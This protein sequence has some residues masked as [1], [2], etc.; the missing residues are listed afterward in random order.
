MFRPIVLLP[1]IWL[2]Q[3]CRRLRNYYD[4]HHYHG[5]QRQNDRHP[6]PSTS[7]IGRFLLLHHQTALHMPPPPLP[8]PPLTPLNLGHSLTLEKNNKTGCYTENPKTV[9]PGWVLPLFSLG[10]SGPW[11]CSPFLHRHTNV[12]QLD[13]GIA[14]HPGTGIHMW[15]GW[16]LGLQ[17]IA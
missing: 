1:Y 12:E 9:V 10:Y 11:N 5:P 14:V 3:G 8:C 15:I 6:R 2:V 7:T 16:S 17:S 13:S 4:H